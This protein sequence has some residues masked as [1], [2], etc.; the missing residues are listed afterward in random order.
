[1]DI[2]THAQLLARIEAFLDRHEMAESRFGRE[3]INNPAFISNLRKEPPVSPTLETLN[4]VGAFMDR[5]DADALTRAKLTAE[6]EAERQEE[7]IALP[8][9]KAPV[10]PTGASSPISS[11]TASPPRRSPGWRRNRRWNDWA[12]PRTSRR[13]WRSS[14]LPP[15]TGSTASCSAPTAGSSDPSRRKDTSE[16]RSRTSR[17]RRAP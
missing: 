17:C 15:G 8:F 9:S 16:C 11:S 12:P 6:P 5:T 4:R 2:P 7:E 1:M 14:P 10:N 3:A 13:S